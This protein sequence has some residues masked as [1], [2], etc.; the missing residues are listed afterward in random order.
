MSH[1]LDTMTQP[2][3]AFLHEIALL[4]SILLNMWMN[5]KSSRSELVHAVTAGYADSASR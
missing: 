5:S 2:A 4:S 3:V 1:P